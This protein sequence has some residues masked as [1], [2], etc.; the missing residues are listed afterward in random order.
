MTT[1]ITSEEALPFDLAA[2]DLRFGRALRRSRLRNIRH[3]RHL[4]PHLARILVGPQS[5]ECGLADVAVAGPAGE[6]DFGD[7]LGLQPMHVARLARRV[8]AAERAFVRGRRLQRRHDLLDLVLAEA[9]ADHAD[10]GEMIAAIDAGHQ[11]AEFSVGGLPAADHDLLPRA[12]LCLGPAFGA[13]GMIGRA[14]ASWRRCLRASSSRADSI[15][16][17]PSTSKCST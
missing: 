15:T 9:G 8:L 7:E 6:L 16:A 3:G 11:R 12:R 1:P 5:L 4:R 13:A 17:S 14:R 10:K 2:D